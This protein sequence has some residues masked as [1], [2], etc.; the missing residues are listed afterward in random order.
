MAWMVLRILVGVTKLLKNSRRKISGV[1]G[2]LNLLVVLPP[3]KDILA[4]TESPI[5]NHVIKIVNRRVCYRNGLIAEITQD[6]YGHILKVEL[7]VSSDTVNLVL[8][9]K[10]IY[11]GKTTAVKKRKGFAK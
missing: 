6:S 7:E 4:A 11:L 1:R 5:S 9:R 8:F 2:T 3:D 10:D